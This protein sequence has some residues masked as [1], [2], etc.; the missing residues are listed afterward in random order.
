MPSYLASVERK[1]GEA[2]VFEGR[3]EATLLQQRPLESAALGLGAAAHHVAAG[4]GVPVTV[5]GA[6]RSLSACAAERR[7]AK[8]GCVREGWG[9]KV[10]ELRLGD[11][12]SRIHAAEQHHFPELVIARRCQTGGVVSPPS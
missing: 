11:A 4:D 5:Y 6:W 1:V 2:R 10:L 9:Q 7:G 12:T 8:S 3:I